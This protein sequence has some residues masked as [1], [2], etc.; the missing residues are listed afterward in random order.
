MP[1]MLEIEH[2]HSGSPAL[3]MQSCEHGT[4]N[5]ALLLMV[6]PVVNM[7]SAQCRKKAEAS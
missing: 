1:A 6:T 2:I 4:V 3:P 7:A 5:T